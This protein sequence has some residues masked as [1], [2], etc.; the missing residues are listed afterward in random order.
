MRQFQQNFSCIVEVSLIVEESGVPGENHQSLTNNAV[1]STPPHEHNFRD[2]RHCT[3]IV[4]V[5][6]NPTTIRSRPRRFLVIK[7]E[8][9][10]LNQ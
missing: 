7:R 4:Q 6:T 5:I 3:L 2:I 1:S 8:V 10:L 9:F